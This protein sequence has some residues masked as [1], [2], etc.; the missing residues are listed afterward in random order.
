MR[1]VV[2]RF[3]TTTGVGVI[4]AI[5]HPVPPGI[6]SDAPIGADVVQVHA[7]RIAAQPV[8]AGRA[9]PMPPKENL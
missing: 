7:W 5:F 8:Y 3:E 2:T 4:D 9:L 1:P 6:A